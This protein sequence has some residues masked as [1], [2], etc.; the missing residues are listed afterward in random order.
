MSSSEKIQTMEENPFGI[1]KQ[2]EL[3]SIFYAESKSSF[4][5]PFCSVAYQYLT[6]IKK[7]FLLIFYKTKRISSSQK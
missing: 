6:D 3:D 4:D 5:K 2:E 7:I 1:D